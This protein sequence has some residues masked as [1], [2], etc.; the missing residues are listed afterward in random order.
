MIMAMIPQADMAGPADFTLSWGVIPEQ[1]KT[2]IA[3]SPL[4]G[5]KNNQTEHALSLN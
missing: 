5:N 1:W 2:T 3:H 4:N